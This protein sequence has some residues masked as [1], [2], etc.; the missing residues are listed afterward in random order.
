MF[1]QKEHGTYQIFVMVDAVH[2]NLIKAY[3]IFNS[4]KVPDDN[5]LPFGMSILGF[6]GQSFKKF[7]KCFSP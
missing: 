7:W 2:W 6:H 3:K 5:K 1:K 4:K